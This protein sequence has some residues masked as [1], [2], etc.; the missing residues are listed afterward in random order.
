[1]KSTKENEKYQ[2]WY[3]KALERT[4][5]RAAFLHFL[6]NPEKD[7]RVDMHM[8]STITRGVRTSPEILSESAK[9]NMD[10]I[11]ITDNDTFKAYY[12][13][14]NK[15]IQSSG[16]SKALLWGSEITTFVDMIDTTT[17]QPYKK[18][19]EVLVYFSD[20]RKMEQYVI[21]GKFPYL[22][23]E[24]KIIRNIK[25]LEHKLQIINDLHITTKP[26]TIDDIIGVTAKNSDGSEILDDDKKTLTIPLASM[27]LSARELLGDLTN[28][29]AA[30]K[31][32]DLDKPVIFNGTAY[33]LNF[34]YFND[35]LFDY[36]KQDK[37]AVRYFL[38]NGVNLNE[39][40]RREF[41]KSIL[42]KP[43]FADEKIWE[44]YPDIEEV[45]KFARDCGGV[46]I[47]AHPA[48]YNLSLP[49]IEYLMLN[50]YHAGID[51]YE[52]MHGFTDLESCRYVY[53]ICERLGAIPTLGSDLQKRH[54]EQGTPTAV[55]QGNRITSKPIRL[56]V[57]N[58]HKF[59]GRDSLE[60]R[61]I[62]TE[63]ARNFE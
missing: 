3:Y 53:S 4:G 14:T 57:K 31:P 38:K 25:S 62:G 1:M 26:I 23:R 17:K 7:T 52:V 54:D 61:P 45:V 36:L 9:R 19:V 22:V 16:Y 27:G 6:F 56:S 39:I 8:H 58:M 42:S 33:E 10:I 40:H 18:R 13:A 24:Y 59:L 5:G 41:N 34:D 28:N 12:S 50:A 60:K 55:G 2:D 46:A 44:G 32:G 63:N 37:Q 21:D 47:L 43:P 35:K 20:P 48:K 49:E 30:I 29:I 11:S 15:D 51:G